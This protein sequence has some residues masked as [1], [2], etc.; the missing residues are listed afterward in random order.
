MLSTDFSP[1]PSS[2]RLLTPM[3]ME[4]ALDRTVYGQTAAKRTLCVGVYQH[5]LSSAHRTQEGEDLGRNHTLLIGPTGSGKTMMMS[6]LAELLGV[7]FVSACATS[8]VESGYRGRPVEDMIRALLHR[9]GND[10]RKAERGI[11]FLD[12]VDKIRRQ[13]VGGGRDISGEGVQNSLLTLLDGR[14]CDAVDSVSIP[15]VDTSRILFVCAGAFA[16]LEE[17]V[18]HRLQSRRSSFGFQSKISC[19]QS[20]TAVTDSQAVMS[21]FETKDLIEYG[22][23]PEFIGRFAHVGVLHELGRDDLRAILFQSSHRSPL[24]QR[25]QVAQLHGITLEVTD[26]AIDA[27]AEQAKAIGTGARA[28]DRILGHS[29]R[30]VEYRWPE[31]ADDR[32]VH[33]IIDSDC[34]AKA[35][36]PQLIRGQSKTV[37]RDVALRN[38]F[39]FETKQPV[40]P[41]CRT[42]RNPVAIDRPPGWDWES[43]DAQ[44][45]WE[46]LERYPDGSRR[47]LAD[48]ARELRLCGA[49]LGEYYA[50][51]KESK[52]LDPAKILETM[53]EIRQRDAGETDYDWDEED[54]EWLG[55]DPDG[56]DI[57][58]FDEFEDPF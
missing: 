6:T 35:G 24:Y 20:G 44:R 53:L 5:Y 51:S 18:A 13:C 49:T 55:Y 38:L 45:F 54:S 17:I 30:S 8:L 48:I 26:E 14:V 1:S 10:P 9:C 40:T 2:R 31:L 21:Q 33:V 37:R 28:L 39:E 50:A 57:C 46:Q 34:I 23:I 22:M 52:I 11:V 15:P 25:Q 7:P 42:M 47:S 19:S 4:A 36:V 29:L 3:S 32:V 56:D 27:I 43:D 12:E 41:A 16:G 58:D